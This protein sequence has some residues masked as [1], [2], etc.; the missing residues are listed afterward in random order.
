MKKNKSQGEKINPN[1][2]K[3]KKQLSEIDKIE[4]IEDIKIYLKK[5]IKGE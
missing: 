4:T 1:K 2:E 5:Q 3:I